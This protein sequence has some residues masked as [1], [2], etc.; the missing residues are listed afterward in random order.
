MF[1]VDESLYMEVFIA[2]RS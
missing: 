2:S 1:F